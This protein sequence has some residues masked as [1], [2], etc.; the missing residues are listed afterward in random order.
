M[1]RISVESSNI[2]SIGYSADH[3]LEVAFKNKN[4]DITSVW[5]YDAVPAPVYSK[6]REAPSKRKFF[7]AEIKGLY[8]AR[9]MEG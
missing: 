4:G 8:A 2:H 7:N 3:T 1:Q 9:K 6:F 5:Q